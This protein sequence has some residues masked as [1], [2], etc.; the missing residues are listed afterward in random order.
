MKKI[1]NGMRYDTEKSI[2]VGE[3]HTPGIGT[4]DFRYWEA[5]LYKTPRSGQFFLAG[6]GHAMTR[7][8]GNYG[9]SQG[10]GEGL[11]PM[12]KDEALAWAEQYLD[13]ETIEK[14]FGDSIKDA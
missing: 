3:Y 6:E 9:D 14:H 1:I 13:A 4:N 2:L 5:S 12:A 11:F 8:A 7:F 10:W